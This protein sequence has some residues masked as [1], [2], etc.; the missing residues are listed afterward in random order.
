MHMAIVIQLFL[1]Y[2]QRSNFHLIRE[3]LGQCPLWKLNVIHLK[4]L[5]GPPTTA[6]QV[7]GIWDDLPK[8][9]DFET[10]ESESQNKT[11]KFK[12]CIS[13]YLIKRRAPV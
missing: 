9:I 12:K 3:R 7:L 4:A 1:D 10:L 5:K 8:D 6:P 11:Q 13:N 2:S